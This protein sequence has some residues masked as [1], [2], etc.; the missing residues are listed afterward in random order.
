MGD[1]DRLDANGVVIAVRREDKLLRAGDEGQRLD[2]R[3]E[4]VVP[5][6]CRLQ[7]QPRLPRSDQ[8]HVR[9]GGEIGIDGFSVKMIAMDMADK[10]RINPVIGRCP[11]HDR[12]AHIRRH[13]RI[14]IGDAEQGVEQDARLA[15]GDQ[16]GFIGQEMRGGGVILG[17]VGECGGGCCEGESQRGGHPMMKARDVHSINPN[18]RCSFLVSPAATMRWLSAR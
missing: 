11:G 5:A 15:G 13:Q 6:L 12:R 10:D 4:G 8:D 7:V 2:A 18:S 1:V 17:R 14:A 9:V 16:D 3:L